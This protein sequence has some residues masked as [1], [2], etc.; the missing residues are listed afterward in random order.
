MEKAMTTV[1][2]AGY[3]RFQILK[4]TPAVRLLDDVRMCARTDC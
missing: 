4:K 1:N 2:R 3:K